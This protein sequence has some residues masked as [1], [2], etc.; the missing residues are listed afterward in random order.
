MTPTLEG[1]CGEELCLFSFLVQADFLVPVLLSGVRG[2]SVLGRPEPNSSAS[3]TFQRREAL[4]DHKLWRIR[5][6][7]GKLVRVRVRAPLHARAQA[8]AQSVVCE[9]AEVAGLLTFLAPPG[10]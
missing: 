5:E 7:E 6:P 10:L 9:P 2:G 1:Q 3:P 8:Q 4:G